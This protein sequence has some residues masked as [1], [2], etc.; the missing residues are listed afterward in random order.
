MPF[1]FYDDKIS[2]TIRVDRS[3]YEWLRTRPNYGRDV[4]GN[5]LIEIM[6]SYQQD[7]R[8]KLENPSPAWLESLL[9]VED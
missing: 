2:I 4:E 6:N 5:A 9:P 1:P 3:L 8:Q 7:R